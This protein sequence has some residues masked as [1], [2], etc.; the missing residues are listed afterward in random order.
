M[1]KFLKKNTLIE[2]FLNKTYYTLKDFKIEQFFLPEDKLKAMVEK[3]SI[4]L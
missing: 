3:I 1:V 2:L 4:L